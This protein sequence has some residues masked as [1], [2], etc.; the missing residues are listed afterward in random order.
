MVKYKFKYFGSSVGL[1]TKSIYHF[2][3]DQIKE[4]PLGEFSEDIAEVLPE[5]K[6]VV[7]KT[8]AK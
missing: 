2:D 4:A 8:K 6:K 3:K 7:V 1:V 5:T